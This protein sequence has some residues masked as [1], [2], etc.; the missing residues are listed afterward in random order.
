MDISEKAAIRK[1]RMTPPDLIMIEGG[2]RCVNPRPT[3]TDYWV[4]LYGYKLGII[5][6]TSRTPACAQEG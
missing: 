6:I 1:N 4:N 5:P 2:V 3:S